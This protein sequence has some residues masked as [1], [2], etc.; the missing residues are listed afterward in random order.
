MKT[1]KHASALLLLLLFCASLAGC[2]KLTSFNMDYDTEVTVPSSTGISLPF[3]IFTPDITT[4]SEATFEV[5]D[6]RKDLIQEISV[7]QLNLALSSPPG[8]SFSFL[9]SISIYLSA[10][11]LNE[12]KIAW[13]DPV[14]DAPG[15]AI[16]LN[17][18]TSDLKEYI[19]KDAFKLRVNTV[20]DE[21]L[22]TDHKINIHSAFHVD[23]KV[24]G[25]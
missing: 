3:N 4:N 1:G 13:K 7:T 18:T 19:K 5:N 23:A 11:G 2:K 24:L 12:I 22:A 21:L 9:K 16:T 20:T 17:V 14:P 6:T 25:L 15:S 10:D 8:G